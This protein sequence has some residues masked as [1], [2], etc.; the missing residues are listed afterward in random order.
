MILRAKTSLCIWVHS[1]YISSC[2]V[3]WKKMK[4]MNLNMRW[5]KMLA[6]QSSVVQL[7]ASHLTFL[8]TNFIWRLWTSYLVLHMQRVYLPL[9]FC[10]SR[11]PVNL[12][13]TQKVIKIYSNVRWYYCCDQYLDINK[14][15]WKSKHW[16]VTLGHKYVFAIGGNND[17]HLYSLAE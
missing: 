11:D 9:Q 17:M 14:C 4:P 12:N 10:A 6:L 7:W 2:L 15:W 1:I 5:L 8:S 3:W 16:W 13:K